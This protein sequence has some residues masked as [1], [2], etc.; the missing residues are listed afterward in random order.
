VNF[1]NREFWFESCCTRNDSNLS[2]QFSFGVMFDLL[3]RDRAVSDLDGIW[4]K[5]YGPFRLPLGAARQTESSFFIRRAEVVTLIWL[6]C[7][8]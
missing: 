4:T 6:D 2:S 1:I 7:S 3:P 8:F 5:L